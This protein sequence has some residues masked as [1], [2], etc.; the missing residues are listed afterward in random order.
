MFLLESRLKTKKEKLATQINPLTIPPEIYN[1][2]KKAKNEDELD[3]LRNKIT[4]HEKPYLRVSK[5]EITD[6]GNDKVL[7]LDRTEIRIAIIRK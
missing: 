3:G 1:Y 4:F 7:V 6:A 5:P 2:L